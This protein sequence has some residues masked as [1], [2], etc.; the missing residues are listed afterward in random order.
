MVVVR[1]WCRPSRQ[2][3]VAGQNLPLLVSLLQ[4]L[5][6]VGS[7]PKE[8][9]GGILQP[10]SKTGVRIIYTSTPN[11]PTHPVSELRARSKQPAS[12]SCPSSSAMIPHHV[13]NH[14]YSTYPYR[15]F[16]LALNPATSM[17][18]LFP[19]PYHPDHALYAVGDLIVVSELLRGRR[20]P[21]ISENSE[22][23]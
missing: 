7:P 10:Y 20:T 8:S 16:S 4:H 19:T 1:R 14:R 15:H 6:R 23:S 2:T 3:H 18:L 12:P 5:P 21:E 11:R 17:W 9:T 22:K 13:S